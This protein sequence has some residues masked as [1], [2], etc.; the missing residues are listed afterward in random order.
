MFDEEDF[1]I[2]REEQEEDVW[3]DFVEISTETDRAWLIRFTEDEVWV[4]MSI[5]EVHNKRVKVPEWFVRKNSELEQY[6]SE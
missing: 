5:G 6:R 3:L 4:P 1:A 2:D